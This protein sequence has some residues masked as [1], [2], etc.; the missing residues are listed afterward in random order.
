MVTE[1]KVTLLHFRGLVLKE[2]DSFPVSTCSPFNLSL[3]SNCLLEVRDNITQ[4][5]AKATFF[6]LF[7]VYS[8]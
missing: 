7:T 2:W 5:D 8:F 1:I 3:D 4:N 6:Q